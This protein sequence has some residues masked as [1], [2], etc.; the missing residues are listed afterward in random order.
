MWLVRRN[1][2]KKRKKSLIQWLD[3]SLI[4]ISLGKKFPAFPDVLI[5]KE[6]V[7][8]ILRILIKSKV[9]FILPT[10]EIFGREIYLCCSSKLEFGLVSSLHRID[11]KSLTLVADNYNRA[12]KTYRG[13]DPGEASQ[14]YLQPGGCAAQTAEVRPPPSLPRPPFRPLGALLVD[15]TF[16]G[17][18]AAVSHLVNAEK[19]RM[20]GRNPV[21]L[22]SLDSDWHQSW[23]HQ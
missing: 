23:S 12:H 16:E 14:V 18:C 13:S 15:L 2:S 1:F 17:T 21:I 6:Q 20:T 3:Q 8:T 11:I 4:I 7:F 9:I 22:H 19:T 10:L 5:A